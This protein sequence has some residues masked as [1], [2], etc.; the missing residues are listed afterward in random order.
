MNHLDH[1]QHN[2]CLATNWGL[3]ETWGS[4]KNNVKWKWLQSMSVQNPCHWFGELWPCSISMNNHYSHTSLTV[5]SSSWTILIT[6]NTH[7]L[8]TEQGL[9]KLIAETQGTFKNNAK[10]KW[11]YSVP[12]DNLNHWFG[13]LWPC[14]ISLNNHSSHT[15]LAACSS[16]WTIW[17]TINTTIV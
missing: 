4:F 17:I 6:I 5:C 2:H 14:S 7:C 9:N 15:S 11:L 12:I 8:A 1:H 16:S 3:R 13:E 10:W